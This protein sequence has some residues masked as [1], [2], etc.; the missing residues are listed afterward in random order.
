[1]VKHVDAVDLR[2]VVAA[3]LEL[4]LI[5]TQMAQKPMLRSPQYSPLPPIPYSSHT[6]SQNLVP[7][8]LPRWPAC[9]CKTR[10]KKQPGGGEHA[11]EKGWGGADIFKKLRVAV[12]H[13]K[14]E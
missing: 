10:A 12:W 5:Q 9:M 13:G 3:E 8:W 11:G 1:V 7:I 14:Q 2:V 4:E 6:N